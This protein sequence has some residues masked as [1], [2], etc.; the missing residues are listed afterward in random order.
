MSQEYT[1]YAVACY[2]IVAAMNQLSDT[3]AN[4]NIS[5]IDGKSV[6]YLESGEPIM[7][8]LDILKKAYPELIYADKPDFDEIQR[9][10]I[11][12]NETIRNLTGSKTST[13]YDGYYWDSEY[14][15]GNLNCTM[16]H[17]WID[18]PNT[19]YAWV[20]RWCLESFFDAG[21]AV[22]AAIWYSSEYYYQLGTGGMV[23][24][25]DSAVSVV[26]IGEWPSLVNEVS[27]AETDFLIVPYSNISWMEALS[28]ANG[29]IGGSGRT[30]YFIHRNGEVIGWVN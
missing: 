8:L 13:K 29:I 20:N 24:S 30:H 25:D 3:T 26:G 7:D 14:Y 12:Q 16:S 11:S 2:K 9:I 4:R 17:V 6:S 28:M 15:I 18:N 19:S 21:A 5:E 22:S 1:D 10:A 23:F 27:F